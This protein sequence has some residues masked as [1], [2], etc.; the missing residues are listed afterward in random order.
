MQSYV[1]AS[2]WT[3][4]KAHRFACIL[5]HSECILE[6]SACILEHS[7]CILEHFACLLEHSMLS[8]TFWNFLH[9]FWNILEHSEWILEHS[10]CILEH[11]ACILEHSGIFWNILELYRFAHCERISTL[12]SH[13]HTDIRTCWA[14][15]SQLKTCSHTCVYT[16][17]K[18]T[19]NPPHKF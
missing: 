1:K 12:N 5:E 10:A 7:A 9:A 17:N 8:G 13:R 18:A 16:F 6:H 14:A 3:C 19:A 4:M 2:S 11:S 15:S